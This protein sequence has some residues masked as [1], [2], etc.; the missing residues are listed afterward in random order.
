MASSIR[1][2]QIIEGP[3]PLLQVGPYHTESIAVQPISY[4]GALVPWSARGHQAMPMD[5]TPL[6]Q[7]VFTSET[8]MYGRLSMPLA[9]NPLIGYY[10]TA[11]LS[12]PF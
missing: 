8:S 9:H 2:K 12:P 5:H 4:S 1:A 7:I 10:L 11:F 6:S 3:L